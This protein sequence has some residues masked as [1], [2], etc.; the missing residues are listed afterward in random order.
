MSYVEIPG[1]K[2]PI[3][4]WTDP[5]S[6]EE[7]ALQQL[8]NVATLPWI[9][10]LAVMP[11]VHY[12]KGAT[13][14][15]VIAM[16][17]AVCPAAVGVD[18]GCGMSAVKTSLTAND[19][20]GDLSRL[21]SKIEQAIPV[22]R[23][24]HDDPVD[25]DRLHG[26]ASGG[27]DGFWE[28]FDGV[29]DAVKFRQERAGKQMGTLGGGNHFVEVCTDSTGSVWLMLHSGSRNIG[30]EL[31]EHHIGIARELPHNQG[32]VDR[33]LAVFVADTPQM[34]AYRNDLFWAQ[35]YA[36]Y[37]RSIMMA[38]LKD[39]VRK[40][41]RKA[42][43]AFEPE[44]S[45]HHNYVAEERY[46]GMDLL[47][48]RKG[49]IRA[50][51][52]E[53]GII[54]GSMGTGSYIVKGL[55]NEKAF[56]SAS[57]GAGRRMSRTAAKRRFSTKDLEEQTRGV[58]CRKDSGVVDEIPGAYKPIEQVIDQQRDLVQVVAKL[59]QVVCVKG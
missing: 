3:R 43:P 31:A 12:G 27:W 25:P 26:F 8:R 59:K 54:P 41:F 33:D 50:G 48:T 35:E 7:G 42:K 2:V 36:R 52:G 32:L 29:A 18:I 15:S 40:E 22:G 51:S 16:R 39:V 14:G 44:I 23:G 20:P 28:R 17:G 30:K 6:V 19:L 49:A 34:A 9:K 47:V 53:Y 10:G 38:L 24:M 55:G 5:A 58:E 1:A 13:V 46:D 11:D 56:N 4:L 45:A 37:N 57:H 21:R